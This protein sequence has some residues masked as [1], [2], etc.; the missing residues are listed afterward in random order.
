[1]FGYWII[2]HGWEYLKDDKMTKNDSDNYG[3]YMGFKYN[4]HSS[5]DKYRDIKY[6]EKYRD[7]KKKKD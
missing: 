2:Q 6:R 1:M 7:S 5:L 4:K 3:N